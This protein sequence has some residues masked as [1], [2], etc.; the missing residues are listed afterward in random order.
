[1]NAVPAAELSEEPLVHYHR[2]NGNATWVDEFAA[3]RGVTLPEPAL[4]TGSPRTAAQLAVAGMGVSIV[5]VS[6]LTPRP[7]GTVRSFDPPELRDVIVVVAAPHDELVARFVA[8]LK[9]RGLPPG[10]S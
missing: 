1:M 4:R 6:A 10:P 7:G 5:P 3:R 8:D 2:S 9:K